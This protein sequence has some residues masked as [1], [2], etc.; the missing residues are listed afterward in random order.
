MLHNAI[1]GLVVGFLVGLTGMGGGSLMAPLLI[2]VFHYK[3]K[4]AVGSDLAYGAIARI[5][6]SWQ[7]YRSG[8]VDVE[9]ALKMSLGSVPG[10]LLGVWA[11]HAVDVRSSHAAERLIT[12]VLGVALLLTAGALIAQSV[13]AVK[14]RVLQRKRLLRTPRFGVAIAIGGTLGFLV[15]MTSVGAGTLFAV[16]LLFVFGLS[17][18]ATVGTDMFHA[19]ILCS[20]AA[21]GHLAVGDVSY[22]L[23]GSLLVGAVP[24][25]IFGSKVSLRTPEF[26][27]RPTIAV[28]LLAS[29]LR[30][31]LA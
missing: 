2:Y 19:V 11:L 22:L 10:S 4:I 21:L 1:A 25:I 27:L 12:H 9:L 14:L 17:A 16:A 23:V 28:V 30:T 7:H 6:G 24:G 31:L 26:V 3:A 13:P 5:F 29:G 20:A 8:S 18:R 15:G